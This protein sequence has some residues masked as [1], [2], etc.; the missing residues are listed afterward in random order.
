LLQLAIKRRAESSIKE[1]ASGDDDLTSR[2]EPRELIGRIRGYFPCLY[3]STG[4]PRE[5]HVFF[6]SFFL[7][8]YFHLGIRS[9]D[10]LVTLGGEVRGMNKDLTPVPHIIIIVRE[11]Q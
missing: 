3:T 7:F 6:F 1:Q 10:S 4:T 2:D 8:F 11:S 5:F 9:E